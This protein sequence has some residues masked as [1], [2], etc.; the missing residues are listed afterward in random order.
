M[1]Q[2]TSHRD[3]HGGT[4]MINIVNCHSVQVGNHSLMVSANTTD[5]GPDESTQQITKNQFG[6]LILRE[7]FQNYGDQTISYEDLNKEM[8]LKL[9]SIE[10]DHIR[11]FKDIAGV[12]L[13]DFLKYNKDAFTI[14]FKKRKRFVRMNM[15]PKLKNS[16]KHLKPEVHEDK[17]KYDR[18][19]VESSDT[20]TCFEAGSDLEESQESHSEWKVVTRTKPNSLSLPNV[21]TLTLD[22]LLGMATKT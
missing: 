7:I 10:M 17:A 3:Q 21:D 18:C 14:Q 8:Q 22:S 11:R 6:L 9:K 4:S 20:D 13:L 16:F 15:K 19:S 1:A 2:V 12:T 5:T